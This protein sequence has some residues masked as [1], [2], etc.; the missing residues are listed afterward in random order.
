M[1]KIAIQQTIIADYRMGLSVLTVDS[2]RCREVVGNLRNGCVA[3]RTAV[4]VKDVLSESVWV[5]LKAAAVLLDAGTARA[6]FER[7]LFY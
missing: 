6:L 1:P 4:A 5:P 3:E 7:E 2:R